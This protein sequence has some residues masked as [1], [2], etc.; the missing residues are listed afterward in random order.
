[1]GTFTQRSKIRYIKEELDPWNDRQSVERRKLQQPAAG[2]E[3]TADVSFAFQV[4]Q[5][6]ALPGSSLADET[7]VHSILLYSNLRPSPDYHQE[8]PI[9]SA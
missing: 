1:M 5:N 3:K 6:V 8:M 7:E 2:V 4:A 9:S